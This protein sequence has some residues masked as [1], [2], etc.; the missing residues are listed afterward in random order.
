M[1]AYAGVA[2]AIGLASCGSPTAV[3]QPGTLEIVYQS[4]LDGEIEPCG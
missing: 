1:R 2:F 3:T 4:R